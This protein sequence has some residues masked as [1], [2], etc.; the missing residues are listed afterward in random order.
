MPV[1]VWA[2]L[3]AADSSLRVEFNQ[4]LATV[5]PPT[6]VASGR[7]DATIPDAF[8]AELEAAATQVNEAIDTLDMA[9]TLNQWLAEYVLPDQQV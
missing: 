7:A 3:A 9:L 5:D 8:I 4:A 2:T 1:P 6:A